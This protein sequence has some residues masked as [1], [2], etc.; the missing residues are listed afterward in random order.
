MIF[1]ET[2]EMGDDGLKNN[3]CIHNRK[4]LSTFGHSLGY[5][6][7]RYEDTQET[8]LVSMLCYSSEAS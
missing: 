1:H 4:C 8:P 3:F 2:M 7:F 5:T 6:Q